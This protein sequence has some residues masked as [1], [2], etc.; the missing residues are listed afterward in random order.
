MPQLFPLSLTCDAGNA[1]S[2]TP[3]TRPT[4]PV[5]FTALA[6]LSAPIASLDINTE[7]EDLIDRAITILKGRD[8]DLYGIYEVSEAYIRSLSDERLKAVIEA[9]LPQ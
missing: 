1:A 9:A 3:I 6:I 5:A 4:G 7:R 8:L 2:L